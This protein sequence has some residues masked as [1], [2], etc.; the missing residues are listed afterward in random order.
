LEVDAVAVEMD[1]NW[2]TVMD[3]PTTESAKSEASVPATENTVEPGEEMI[4]L[5]A[6]LIVKL[7]DFVAPALA[8]FN[9]G[10]ELVCW[11]IAPA[12]VSARPKNVAVKNWKAVPPEV[13]VLLV[14]PMIE[15]E[16]IVAE[17]LLV[18]TVLVA[19]MRDALSR[20]MSVDWRW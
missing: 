16:L 14:P 8:I 4:A 18:M 12:P 13:I 7:A 15:R 3:P 17:L 10:N 20:L 11:K 6:I 9:I 5:D 1:A 19:V 2:P